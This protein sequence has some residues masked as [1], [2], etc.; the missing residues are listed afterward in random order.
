[1]RNRFFR[2]LAAC[3]L[4]LS[5]SAGLGTSGQAQAQDIDILVGAKGGDAFR[6]ARK[7]AD[8]KTIFAARGFSKAFRTAHEHLLTCGACTVT[9][10]AA[11]GVYE[12]KGG[13]GV[14]I[15]PDIQAPE[16]RL[17][18]LGG[19]DD[20]FEGRAPFDN[21]TI[22][23]SPEERTIAL[24]T[25]EG[26]K[27]ALQSLTL[28]GLTFD[29]GP[30]NSY[31]AETNSLLKAESPSAPLLSLG[32]L[33]VE[34]LVIADNLFLNAANS[35]AQP[36]VRAMSDTAEVILRNNIIMGNV[37]AWRVDSARFRH[38]P[39]RYVIERNS[40]L[41]NWPYNPDPTTS[42]P[43]ALEVG[44]KYAAGSVEIVGNLFAHNH[45]GAIHLT[46]D[47]DKGPPTTI[48]GN[49]FWRN[50]GLF[51]VEDEGGAAVVG[52]FLRAAS[53]RTLDFI[54]IEDFDWNAEEND[55]FDPEL[56]LQIAPTDET[57]DG[58]GM[59]DG[60][61]D[62]GAD[63][64]AVDELAALLAEEGIEVDDGTEE[65]DAMMDE[66]MFGDDDAFFDGGEDSDDLSVKDYAARTFVTTGALPIPAN[67][68][69]DGYGA[70]PSL[71]EGV[72]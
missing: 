40:F 39:A 62:D 55:S 10:K 35:A 32:Y 68:D 52:K 57:S 51:D 1:M 38:I 24:L 60:M 15:F 14:W 34:R 54:D 25:F 16:A 22:L 49:L 13:S 19:W 67:P 31:D 58:D 28:S 27:H 5:L 37:L 12:G 72:Q 69:A 53:H 71:V 9:I 41:M 8:K 20:D 21:Q 33:T 44:G 17:A 30:S 43:G 59:G 18:I 48:A 46:E 50:G 61:G 29:G 45:G 66:D 47:D 2:A 65:D 11:G 26:K 70:H 42:N 7:M 3:A 4:G 36:K 64:G 63:G 56:R 23:Q 6:N